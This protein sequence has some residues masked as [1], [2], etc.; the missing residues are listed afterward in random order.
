MTCDSAVD[1]CVE[2]TVDQVLDRQV[3][4]TE[5]EPEEEEDE[6]AEDKVTFLDAPKGLEVVRKYMQESDTDG[7][8]TVMCCTHES[9]L[10]RCRT[11]EK[12]SALTFIDSLN[13]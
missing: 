6:V 9:N 3:T 11:E 12:K 13:K 4:G 8:I 10:C 5:E 2:S 7:G 1:V